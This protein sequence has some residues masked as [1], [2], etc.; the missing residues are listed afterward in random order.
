MFSVLLLLFF[1][2][3]SRFC[4]S[5]VVVI[6]FLVCLFHGHKNSCTITINFIRQFAVPMERHTK[7]N[8]SWGDALVGKNQH[9]YRSLTKDSAKVSWMLCFLY[10]FSLSFVFSVN[11]FCCFGFFPFA[12]FPMSSFSLW[13]CV[14]LH[15]QSFSSSAM[16]IYIL[17]GL[18]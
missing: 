9:L 1:F 5:D 18:M 6:G 16:E 3:L 7:Q 4:C 12:V 13:V 11:H 17:F 15:S 2:S 10:C 14:C 8:A